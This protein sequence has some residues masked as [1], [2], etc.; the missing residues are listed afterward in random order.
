MLFLDPL[1]LQSEERSPTPPTA[2]LSRV[3]GWL[4]EGVEGSPLYVWLGFAPL[5]YFSVPVTGLGPKVSGYSYSS[6]AS[7]PLVLSGLSG[8]C[9]NTALPA[10]ASAKATD[11]TVP[12]TAALAG[13]WPACAL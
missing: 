2:P 7:A 11:V 5:Y 13:N 6:A 9:C 12:L 3:A 8:E 10:T 1:D 4:G